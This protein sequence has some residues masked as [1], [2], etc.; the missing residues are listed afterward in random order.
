MYCLL[1]VS[2]LVVWWTPLALLG[3]PGSTSGKE[4]ACQCK[5]QK[6]WGFDPW[7]GKI[8]WRREWQ[9]T[10]VFLPWES[11]GLRMLVGLF[12]LCVCV[13]AQLCPTLYDPMECSPP[14][15]SVHGISQ[16]KILK[17]ESPFPPPGDLPDP[18]IKPASPASAGRFCTTAP[19]RKTFIFYV[20]IL[21][22]WFVVAMRFFYGNLYVLSSVLS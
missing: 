7:V 1:L 21:S 22:F 15:S 13:C 17:N 18:G 5:R 11:Y 4:P 16:V 14:G 8:P 12:F 20:S 19:W 3:F 9:P 10:P 6:R 2:L